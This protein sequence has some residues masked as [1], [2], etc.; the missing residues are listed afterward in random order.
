MSKPTPSSENHDLR[1]LLAAV[2]DALTLDYGADGYDQRLKERAGLAKVVLKEVA[3]G[4]SDD[5]GWE[6]DWLRSKLTAEQA[7]AEAKAVRASVNRAFPIVAAFLN[8][9]RETGQ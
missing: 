2:L 8:E 6:A 7:D 3:A 1:Q 4:T 9:E 5:I